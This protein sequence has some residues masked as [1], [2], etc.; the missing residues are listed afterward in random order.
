ML[1]VDDDEAE[2]GEGDR[3]LDER[4]RADDDERLTGGDRLQRLGLDVGLERTR[5]QRDADADVLEQRAHRLE[6]LACEQVGRG[7]QSS[8]QT[9]LGGGRECVGRDRGLARPHVALQESQHRGRAGE[10]VTDRVDRD[11]LV[12]G[13]VDRGTDPGADRADDRSADRDVRRAVESDL[14]G[15]VADALATAGDHPELEGQELVEGEAAQRRVPTLERL[16]VV[17]LL[18][19]PGDRHEPFVRDD[20][21]RQVLGIGV[22]GLVERLADGRPQPDRGQAGGQRVDRHDPA[23]VEQLGLPH[24]AGDDLELRVVEGQLAAEMLDLAGHDDLAADEQPALD[25]PAPEP[26]RVDA[27]AVVLEPRDGPLRPAAKAG[28]DPDVADACLGRDDRAVRL[29]DQVAELAHLA[30]VVVPPRQVE[31]QVADRVEVELDPGPAQGRGGRQPGLRQRGRQQLD[32]IGR[33]R[34]RARRLGHAYSAAI[35]YR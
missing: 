18:D 27:A 35:R 23:D 11:H 16:G 15:G 12:D 22:A 8:L 5:E 31:E 29:P 6:V 9:G 26:G 28:L 19:R 33:G 30:Q 24:L 4:V 20:L 10:V 13:Q 32:R 14:R 34:N 21:G 2:V 3:V 1:L 17:G 7:E 25:E